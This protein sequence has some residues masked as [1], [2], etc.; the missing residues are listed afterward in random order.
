[1]LN[2]EMKAFDIK[3]SVIFDTL[4]VNSLTTVPSKGISV[5]PVAYH[6]N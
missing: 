5:D 2:D 4:K 3:D 1:M 6:A